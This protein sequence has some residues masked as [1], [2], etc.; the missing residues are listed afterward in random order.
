MLPQSS[1]LNSKPSK[2]FNGLHG[3]TF[4]KIELFVTI[5]GRTRD[6]TR[7]IVVLSLLIFIFLGSRRE[8]KGNELACSQCQLLNYSKN[9]QLLRPHRL[10]SVVEKTSS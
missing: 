7:K 5:A 9:V 8:G 1:G 10:R 3:V 4:Q 2:K 6:L